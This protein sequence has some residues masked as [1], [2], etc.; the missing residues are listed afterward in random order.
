MSGRPSRELFVA[1]GPQRHT[2]VNVT[3]ESG[4][5]R[6]AFIELT[7]FELQYIQTLPG[8]SPTG[9]G[10]QYIPVD[11]YLTFSA[12]CPQRLQSD[13][14]RIAAVPSALQADIQNPEAPIGPLG[15]TD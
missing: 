1:V 6:L 14:Q 9:S 2:E 3:L 10:S 4:R 15:I 8:S 11:P 12:L 5:S 13:L 7:I